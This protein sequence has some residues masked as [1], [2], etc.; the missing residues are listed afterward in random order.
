MPSFKLVEVKDALV[1]EGIEDQD[2]YARIKHI[3]FTYAQGYYLHKPTPANK[4]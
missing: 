2:L 1:A 4:L 3:G